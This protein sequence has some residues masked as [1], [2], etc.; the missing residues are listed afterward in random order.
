MNKC[1]YFHINPLKNEIFYVGIG[2]KGRPY[3]KKKRSKYW[4]DIVSRFGYIIDI[5]KDGIDWNGACKLEIFYIKKIGRKDLGLGNLV[6]KT[7]G[8][9]GNHNP[10]V[11][12]REIHRQLLLGKPAIN[13]GKKLNYSK[14][15]RER[16]SLLLKG[17][18]AINKGKKLGKQSK[19][20]IEKRVKSLRKYN[21]PEERRLANN[22]IQRK[23]YH[24]KKQKNE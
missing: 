21:T 15:E 18:P 3:N 16:R 1:V 11:E 9:E 5:V 17:K 12:A 20:L 24:T 2:G 8:G 13:K 19:E 10:S 22:K 7:N 6:N 14:E 23:Y 4:Y